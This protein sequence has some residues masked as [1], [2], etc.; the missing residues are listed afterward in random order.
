LVSA[1]GIYASVQFIRG[2][3]AKLL[4]LALTLGVIVDLMALIA[5]PLIQTFLQEPDR[6]VKTIKSD[7]PDAADIEITPNQDRLDAQRVELGIV[8][9]GIYAMLSLYLI[10][11]PVKKYFHSRTDRAT[12]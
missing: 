12:W 6:I 3:S 8:L 5:L 1:F 10:S 7:R 9:I 11:P 4:M 2:K